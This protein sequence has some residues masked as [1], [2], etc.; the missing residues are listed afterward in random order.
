ALY[1]QEPLGSMG[2]DEELAVLSD[3]P[4][5]LYD[6]FRQLFAQVT[7]PPIDPYRES[8]VMSLMSFVGRERNLLDETPNHCRQLKLSHPML[9]NDDI[10]RLRSSYIEG[11]R[12]CT[13]PILFPVDSEDPSLKKA[14]D[15]ICRE[16]E[17]RVNE[18]YSLIILSDRNMSPQKAPIPAL[19]ATSA[20]HHYLVRKGIRHLSGLIVETG[21][22]REVHHF[23]TLI[24]FGASGI[25]PYLVFET[26]VDLKDRNYLPG[27][28][29]IHNAIEGYVSA[30][31]KGL[32][33]VMSKMGVSTIRSY[34]GS[35]IYE[36]VGLEEHFVEEYFTGISSPIGGIGLDVIEHEVRQ[37]HAQA[38]Q[39]NEG[40]AGISSGGKYHYR[41][42]QSK[43]LFT[44]ESVALLQHAVRKGDYAIFKQYSSEINNTGKTLCTIRGLFK[45]KKGNPVP[46][47]EV[48]SEE[49]IVKRFV[50]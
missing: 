4:R 21:E 47:E 25:N 41:L 43:H 49:E 12:V 29:T 8:L 27:D 42:G 34:R 19:L 45:L 6:Y 50:S 22:A 23:A 2:N 9:T 38:Y 13:V 17:S 39:D 15:R 28:M 16:T 33:K 10:E 5:L 24:G 26:I 35:Q 44:P 36:S 3:Q 7:N 30:V 32:L 14:L 11:F 31:K 46:I 1:S 48:E 20:V 18:G 40:E 37:R